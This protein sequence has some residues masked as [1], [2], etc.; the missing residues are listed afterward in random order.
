MSGYQLGAPISS[1]GTMLQDRGPLNLIIALH[2][3][4]IKKYDDNFYIVVIYGKISK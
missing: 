1:S 2:E 4:K 3:S